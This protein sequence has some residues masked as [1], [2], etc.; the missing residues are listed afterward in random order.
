M[1]ERFKE[2]WNI[3]SNYQLIIILIVFSVTGSSSL[4]VRKGAFY[5]LGITSE[6]ELWLRT[7]LYIL[8][9]VPA[10][11]VMLLI[12]GFLFGQ[13]KFAWE[14]EKKMLGRFK[15]KKR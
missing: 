11:Y 7:I 15:F 14:F 12:V 4:Y 5:M 8:I 9:I 10:Y 3:K 1:L 13:F 2:R 6:T